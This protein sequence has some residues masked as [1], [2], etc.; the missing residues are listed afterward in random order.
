[1]TEKY[2]IRRRSLNVIMKFRSTVPLLRKQPSMRF[3]FEKG[4]FE[5]PFFIRLKFVFD[6]RSDCIGSL[7]GRRGG[8][9]D[10]V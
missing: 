4:R 3:R 5:P 2:P 10:I 7:I 6:I 1:M 8:A 9:F